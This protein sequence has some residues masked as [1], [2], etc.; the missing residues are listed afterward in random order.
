M[1]MLLPNFIYYTGLHL[2][3]TLMVFILV[4]FIERAD[5]LLRTNKISFLNVLIIGILG[6]S[7]FFLRTVLAMSAIFALFSALMLSKK[8]A[9]SWLNRMVIGIW[10]LAI[11]GFFLAVEIQQEIGYYFDRQDQQDEAMRFRAEREGGNKLATYGTTV[12]FLPFMAIAPFPTFVNIETQEQ[13]MLLSGAYFVRNVYAFFVILSV[14]F[15]LRR[16][17]LRKHVLLLSLI[18]A[19]FFIL[20]KSSFAIS[21]RF[22]LP[23]VPFLLVFA[24]YGISLVAKK[25][26]IPFNL[27]LILITAIVIGWNVFKLAGRG[28]L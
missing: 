14:V 1:A 25:D 12:I 2:K 8:I 16:K 17:M 13:Q 27:Y 26:R 18:L 24:A 10:F 22:H 9:R 3:E 5:H 4:A 20:A 28:I 21:E 19:Y 15:L 6:T 7:M 23:L 11:F